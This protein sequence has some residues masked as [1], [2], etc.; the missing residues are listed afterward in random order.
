MQGSSVVKRSAVAVWRHGILLENP[1]GRCV[2][3]AKAIYSC[4]G[5]RA[6]NALIIG[7]ATTG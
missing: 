7:K 6:V 1:V 5:T 3:D 2:G 4:E